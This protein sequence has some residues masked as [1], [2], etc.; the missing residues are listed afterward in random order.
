M[1][2]DGAVAWIVE[3]GYPDNVEY[4]VY[5]IDKTGRRMLASSAD[6]VPYSLALAGNTVY[7]TQGGQPASTPLN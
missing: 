2:S 1:K 4:H 3:T 5:A 6:I 7:W